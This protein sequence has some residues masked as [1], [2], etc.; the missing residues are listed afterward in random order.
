VPSERDGHST[1]NQT[2]SSAI[3]DKQR[4]APLLCCVWTCLTVREKLMPTMH[5]LLMFTVAPSGLVQSS[6]FS[7]THRP[8]RIVHTIR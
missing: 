7:T 5:V 2:G 4:S 6:W 1:A 3:A 8:G